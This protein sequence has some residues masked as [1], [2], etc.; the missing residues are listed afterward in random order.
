MR[1]GRRLVRAKMQRMCSYLFVLLL[2]TAH[3]AGEILSC[4]GQPPPPHAEELRAAQQLAVAVDDRPAASSHRA[5]AF[6]SERARAAAQRLPA[7]SVRG[8]YALRSDEQ[9][10]DFAG[11]G[12]PLTDTRFPYRQRKSA[13]LQARARVPLYTS[14][15]IRSSIAAADATVRS[16]ELAC[17]AT[18]LDVMTAA[19]EAFVEVLRQQRLLAVRDASVRTL[20]RRAHDVRMA[21]EQ[22]M[23]TRNELLTA[24]VPL[25]KSCCRRSTRRTLPGRSTTGG[26]SAR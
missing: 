18:R 20:A 8:G 21:Y 7:V 14:G 4:R 3:T 26:S 15:R 17:E 11:S 5:H 24:N 12:L 1:E 19:G 25:S 16:A 23:A 10:F 9:A 2:V 6:E 22:G 13:T